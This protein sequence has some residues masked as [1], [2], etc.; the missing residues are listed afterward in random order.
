MISAETAMRLPGRFILEDKGLH[1]MRGFT[2]PLRIFRV[3]GERL[4]GIHQSA[5]RA[6]EAIFVGRQNELKLLH[7]Y[8]VK[9]LQGR[10][11]TIMIR[12]EAGI[13]KSRLAGRFLQTR[14]QQGRSAALRIF[15][16]PFHADEPL[17]PIKV[18]LEEL[19]D[20][21]RRGRA[22]ARRRLRRLLQ[23]DYDKITAEPPLMAVAELLDLVDA[24]EAD[25]LRQMS[26]SQLKAL[27]LDAL[28]KGASRVAETHSLLLLVEDAH[29]LDPTTLEV[30]ERLVAAAPL[31]RMLIIVTMRGQSAPSRFGGQ[32]V[33]I[34]LGGLEQADAARLFAAIRGT[35]TSSRIGRELAARTGGVPLFIEEFA[36]AMGQSGASEALE[37][38]A[39]LHECLAGQLDRAGPAKAIAQAAAVVGQKWV[40]ADTLAAVAEWPESIVV[41][42]LGHLEAVGLVERSRRVPVECWSFRHEL[43]RETAYDSLVRD[44]RQMLHSR[45]ADV[46]A[47][48]SE[49]VVLAHHLSEAGRLDESVAYFIRA[50]RRGLELFSREEAVRLLRRGLSALDALPA[51]E[52]RQGQRL[53]LMA[54]L[55]SALISLHGPG[56]AVTQE[57]YRDAV[58]LAGQLPNWENH[59]P[60]LWGWWRLSHLRDFSESRDRAA[61]LHS[62]V[63]RHGDRGLLL[64]AHHCNWAA[65]HNQGEFAGSARHAKAGLALYRADEHREHA[66]VYGNHDAK[67]CAHIHRMLGLWQRGFALAAETEEERAL[68]WAREL[69]DVA[70]MLH[71]LEF[72]LVH[73]AYRRR[74]VEVQAVA[75]R[76]FTMATEY[77]HEHYAVRCRIFHGWATAM[78]GDA[79]CGAKLAA[80]A[81]ALEHEVSTPDHFAVFHCLV[82]EAWATAGETD[83]ALAELTSARAMFERIGLRHWLPEVWR[84]IGDLTIA[85]DPTNVVGA[86]RAYVKSRLLAERQGAHRLTLRS[87]LSLAR[88]A[89]PG[90]KQRIAERLAEVLTQVPEIEDDADEMINATALAASH[91][92]PSGVRGVQ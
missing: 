70:S 86:A 81:L 17:W 48:M 8:W 34:S 69:Q 65:L 80:D 62:K 89:S 31:H 32:A 28:V 47:R 26:P 74:P 33:A 35:S 72:S 71:A 67:V 25:R 57:L 21:R 63:R 13:G 76:L 59:F 78:L 7:H 44:R 73:R 29:W 58:D 3:I 88:I 41:Q 40:S 56:A 6:P 85:S 20:A 12:G 50:A 43:L 91:S 14:D 18:A 83:R 30:L 22:R 64:Q 42:A 23:D 51:T 61:W 39:T 52:S 49:P 53:E 36:R 1:A 15:G 9:A 2:E 19:V 60:I 92:R 75:D 84:M 45:A 87:T 79:R 4:H 37:I 27:T 11:A 77:G 82:A 24:H 16:S 66:P 54:L 38:P 46:L 5:S 90:T 68:S 55:G 10:G